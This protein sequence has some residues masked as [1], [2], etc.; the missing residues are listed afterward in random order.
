MA[1]KAVATGSESAPL[2]L[3]SSLINENIIDPLLKGIGAPPK[4]NKFPNATTELRSFLQS[5]P[6]RALGPDGKAIKNF[7]SSTNDDVSV[8]PYENEIAYLKTVLDSL[9]ADRFYGKSEQILGSLSKLLSTEEFTNVGNKLLE[10]MALDDSISVSDFDADVQSLEENCGFLGDTRTDAIRLAKLLNTEKPSESELNEILENYNAKSIKSILE[11]TDV[12]GVDNLYKIFSCPVIT[13]SHIPNELVEFYDEFKL[14]QQDEGFIKD[15]R[16]LEE[17]KN[18]NT[19][20]KGDIEE[21]HGV[22]SFGLKVIRHSLLG[23]E[24]TAE[25]VSIFSAKVARIVSGLENEEKKEAIMAGKL[26]HFEVYCSLE[27]EAQRKQFSEALDEFNYERQKQIEIRGIEGAKKRWQ[28]KFEELQKRGDVFFHSSMSAWCYSWLQAVTPLIEKEVEL[29]KQHLASGD[30]DKSQDRDLYAPFLAKVDPTRAAVCT[31]LELLK[32]H[33]TGGVA[34]GFRVYKAVS[35]VGRVIETEVR[36]ATQLANEEKLKSKSRSP[37][38]TR[39]IR[40]A[41]RRKADQTPEWD[42]YTRARVG[43]FLVSALVTAAK[44][45]VSQKTLEGTVQDEHPA[46]FHTVQFVGGNR[47]GVI[48]IH[49]TISKLLSGTNFSECIQP[50]MLPMLIEPKPWSSYYGGGAL[51][52]RSGLVRMKDSPE[53]MAYISAATKRGNLQEVFDGLNVL[54][55]TPWTVNS[56]VFDV[57]ATYWNKGEEF[58]SIPPVQDKINLPESLPRDADPQDK[59]RQSSSYHAAVREFAGNH[60]RRCDNNYKLEIA[61]AYIGEKLFF[62]HNLD[63]RGRAYP[64][65]PH[66]NHLGND[67]TRS[68]FMFWEGK[69]LGE[70]G[71]RWLKVQLAN[72]CGVDKESFD[73]RVKFVDNNLEAIIASAKDPYAEGAF[74]QKADKP[75]QALGACFELAAAYELDDPTKFVSHLPVHQ[76]GTC[77]GLQHYAALG[78]DVEGAMQINLSPA[79]KPQDV[80]Q[81]VAGLV[82]ERLKKDAAQGNEK[83]K[84]LMGNIKRKVVKQTVMTNVYGVTFLGGMSQLQKQIGHLFDNNKQSHEYALYLARQVFASIREL[85]ENAHLIQDWL[86]ISAKKIT[87]SV[88]WDTVQGVGEH[89]R[90]AVIWTSPLGLPVIQPYR[91]Q[92]ASATPAA[93]Q[94]VTVIRPSAAGAVDS[95][96][97][98]AGFPPNYVH[99]LDATHMLMSAKACGKAGLNFAAVH[100]SFWTHACDVPTMNKLIR[101]SFVELHSYDLIHLLKE[102]FDERYKGY[103]EIARIPSNHPLVAEVKKV[104]EQWAKSLN[105]SVSLTDEL[106]MEKKRLE[107]LES[108][109]PEERKAAENMKTTIS[110]TLDFDP[111]KLEDKPNTTKTLVLI[112]LKFPPVPPRGEFDVNLV[113]E[114]KYFFS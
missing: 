11:N 38:L 37:K 62:P 66:F 15:T 59:L 4:L 97:Q 54:G 93:L 40:D 48:K 91:Q 61:R 72:V 102:E 44:V 17:D 67:L 57:I 22:D 70:V 79:D 49:P 111:N 100:D 56:K 85:F 39:A 103:Y 32:L 114:S 106:Y 23:L 90:S 34:S 68:L 108:T 6:P 12:F 1:T 81:F 45:P 20:K 26:N 75:W 16:N 112:P 51:F 74:W 73:D 82:E 89:C 58:L 18:I 60:S 29:C 107:M 21:L 113:K 55:T 14:N 94:K 109:N 28:H 92:E 95:R 96:K 31:I 8:D 3:S 46:F 50:Q 99:S 77:N 71:L 41:I 19:L 30:Q 27:T 110:V 5:T 10:A 64:L 76:D 78:G 25:S 53:T 84:F 98:A 87:R 86:T 13:D 24:P 43:G 69:E 35:S 105:G 104:K 2:D 52:S 101:E 83:A 9:V 7:Y 36:V 80:Y 33:S 88:S 63:F 42:N 47:Y 65:S